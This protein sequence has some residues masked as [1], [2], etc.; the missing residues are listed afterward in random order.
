[1]NAKERIR[2]ILNQQP[3]DRLGWDFLDTERKDILFA[4]FAPFQRPEAEGM[5]SWGPYPELLAF[6]RTD[7]LFL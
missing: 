3:H 2:A 5:T 7:D 1:M 4:P 6:S